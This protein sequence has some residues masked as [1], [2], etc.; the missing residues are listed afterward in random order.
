MFDSVCEK[1]NNMPL[2]LLSC[3]TLILFGGLRASW[4]APPRTLIALSPRCECVLLGG[5]GML[6]SGQ[7]HD[8]S[9]DE[10]ST[11]LSDTLS[12]F[13]RGFQEGGSCARGV[14]VVPDLHVDVDALIKR[15][16]VVE[17]VVGRMH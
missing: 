13:F 11:F 4:Q 5:A 16:V 17:P 3:L 12:E 14:A 6:G 9:E 2:S 1:L 7:R 10:A 15:V 8:Q